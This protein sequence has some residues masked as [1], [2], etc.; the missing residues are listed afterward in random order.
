MNLNAPELNYLAISLVRS[1]QLARFVRPYVNKG[2]WWERA[3]AAL[4]FAG[5]LYAS[6]FGRRRL[7]DATLLALTHEAGVFADM[8]SAAVGR[9]TFLPDEIRHRWTNRLRMSVRE[10]VAGDGQKFASAVQCVVAYEGFALPAFKAARAA[11]RGRLLLNYPVAHHRA[12]RRIRSEENRREPGFAPTWPGFDDWGP[13]H[14]ERLD[15]EIALADVVLLGSQ[16]AADSFVAEGIP[17]DKLAV[18]PYGVDQRVF[19]P[20]SQAST[21]ERPF[22]VIYAGQL[23]QRKG[24]AY[25]LRAYAAFRKPD[26]ELTLVGDVVGS[27]EPLRPFADH[28]THVPH[29]TRPALAQRY[30]EASVFVLP[31][32]MEGMP[33]VV[34]EAMACGLPVVVTPNGPAGIVRDGVDGFIVPERDPGAIAHC[35]Q[36]L[37]DDPGLRARMGRNAATRALEFSW[38]V[39]A[40]GVRR[41]LTA[42]DG[43]DV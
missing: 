22:K 30:R 4:P 39:Y 24:I 28:F 33:L 15:R 8:A 36:R 18:V 11:G 25:L 9:C 34:L 40:M 3:L 32:L 27:R 29:Q 38:D 13:G 41:Q 10:A 5:R 12:R 2:R 26:T 42:S 20:A 16:F 1:G 31:T 21:S 19:R 6:T 14:E 23:T 17:P 43:T 7:D 35:L 37:Y